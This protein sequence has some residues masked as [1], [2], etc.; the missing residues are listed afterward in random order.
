MTNSKH[1]KRA[2]L[3]SVLSLLLC[4]SML[5]GSTFAWFTDSVTADKNK[6]VAGNLDIELLAKTDGTYN[7]V[8]EETNL[9]LKDALWEPG[10][11]EVLNL[12]VAN[13]GTLAL[14]YQ[15]G[16]NIASEKPGTNVA[17][18]SFL[19]SEYIRYALIQDERSFAEGD[20]GRAD[21]IE[22]AEA[23]GPKKLSELVFDDIGILY[24]AEKATPEHPSEKPITLIV[25]MPTDVGNIANYKTG[26]T[27]SEIEFGVKLFATQTPYEWDN[28]NDQYDALAWDNVME[29]MNPL[30][31][32]LVSATTAEQD[33]GVATFDTEDSKLMQFYPKWIQPD[34]LS[35]FIFSVTGRTSKTVQM[36]FDFAEKC[37]PGETYKGIAFDGGFGGYG[38]DIYLPAGT[39]A[40][41][42]SDGEFT[43]V[44]DY[45]PYVITVTPGEANQN[46]FSY[47]G[48]FTGLI[49]ALS[50][51]FTLE[52][53]EYNDTFTVTVVWPFETSGTDT[54]YV[55]KDGQREL[56]M[57]RADTHLGWASDV[58]SLDL[59]ADFEVMFKE[60][61]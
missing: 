23:A 7:K 4:A 30:R 53:G 48:S 45:H 60:R 47:K 54:C 6:I 9:F 14:K 56:L 27:P 44:G 33:M 49:E 46:K 41:Y 10:H 26:T 24:P 39:Y 2:L 55:E 11:V 35:T 18:D 57:D 32:D 5:V 52:P 31:V 20:T 61:T 38:N 16:I 19:L 34:S 13:L 50:T 40:D 36:T 43:L 8:T 25:Y 29:E 21:A 3:I 12:K 15:F 22:A 1:T 58:W 51:G 42:T 28:F 59:W 17:N 37:R